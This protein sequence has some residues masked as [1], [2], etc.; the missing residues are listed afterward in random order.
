M[1]EQYAERSSTNTICDYPVAASGPGSPFHSLG[2]LNMRFLS[3]NRL[4]K[5]LCTDSLSEHDAF[6]YFFA[7]LI[8]ETFLVHSLFTFSDAMEFAPLD[9]ANALTPTFIVVA[10]TWILYLANGGKGGH[11]FFLR[12]FSILWVVGV[13]FLLFSSILLV[14]WLRYFVFTD[15]DSDFAYEWVTFV[16]SNILHIFFYWRVWMHMREVQS[17]TTT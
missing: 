11:H 5:E 3:I 4:K 14:V 2:Y 1:G 9:I 8:V 16:V 6:V 7:A 15:S 12:Y 17:G 13:R 10:A